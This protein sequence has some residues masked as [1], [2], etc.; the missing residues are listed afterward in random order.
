VDSTSI[1]WTN[2]M[3]ARL[4]WASGVLFVALGIR[5]VLVRQR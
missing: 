2:A 3:E 1:S 5:L 4:D